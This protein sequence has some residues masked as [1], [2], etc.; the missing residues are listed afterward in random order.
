M[1]G[2]RAPDQLEKGIRF[3]CGLVAGAILGGLGA[4]YSLADDLFT[5]VLLGAGMALLFGFSRSDTVTASGTGF[6]ICAG[7]G[8]DARPSHLTIQ[9]TGCSRCSHLGRRS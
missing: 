8:R 6:V 4:L 1:N 5:C 9:R 3:G 7:F 2:E